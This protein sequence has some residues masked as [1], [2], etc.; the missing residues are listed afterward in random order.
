MEHFQRQ[1]LT[2]TQ[3]AA[4]QQQNDSGVLSQIL[5]RRIRENTESY[6]HYIDD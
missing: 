4:G 5:A 2:V 6:L 1:W 3:R